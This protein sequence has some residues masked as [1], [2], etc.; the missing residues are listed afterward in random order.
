MAIIRFVL[1][2]CMEMGLA[3][4]IT[5]T[6]LDKSSFAKPSDSFATVAAFVTL[7]ALLCAPIY[8]SRKISIFLTGGET[9]RNKYK[10]LFS[11]MKEDK[12]AMAFNVIF[13]CRRYFMILLLTLLPNNR[14]T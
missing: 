3:A 12:F 5:T 4:M 8:L 2:G 9:Q 10:Q 13:F 14:N 11:N 1:E 7:F 6:M